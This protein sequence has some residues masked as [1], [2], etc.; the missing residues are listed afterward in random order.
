MFQVSVFQTWTFEFEEKTEEAPFPLWTRRPIPQISG[1]RASGPSSGRV[2]PAVFAGLAARTDPSP[3]SSPPPQKSVRRRGPLLHAAPKDEERA[4]GSRLYLL[5][6]ERMRAGVM[7]FFLREGKKGRNEKER[8][9][10]ER[11]YG[12]RNMAALQKP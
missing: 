2:P 1:I 4:S 8:E 12:N 10:E 7:D 11:C 3:A 6:R 9:T 5:E